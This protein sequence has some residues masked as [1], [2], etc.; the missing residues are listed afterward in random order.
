MNKGMNLTMRDIREQLLK[1]KWNV[2]LSISVV[3]P[4]RDGS[5]WMNTTD[6]LDEANDTVDCWG[7]ND[8]GESSNAPGGTFKSI[9]G[10]GLDNGGHR[11]YSCGVTIA[12][13]LLDSP[14]SLRP[15]RYGRLLG[16]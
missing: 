11:A 6:V 5:V 3:A 9:C 1:G 13:A 4:T 8:D 2:R 12:G 7:R 15:Q 10:Y 16:T 14:S